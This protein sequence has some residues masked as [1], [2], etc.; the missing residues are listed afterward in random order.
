M[1]NCSVGCRFVVPD[2][3][4]QLAST[5]AGAFWE[6][7]TYLRSGAPQ[8]PKVARAFFE[9]VDFPSMASGPGGDPGALGTEAAAAGGGQGVGGGLPPL[10][11]RLGRSSLGRGQ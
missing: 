5:P 9:L 8:G 3:P 11:G 1:T 2:N 7:V 6:G 4:A 10:P